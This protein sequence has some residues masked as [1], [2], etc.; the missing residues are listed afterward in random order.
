MGKCLK[1]VLFLIS[2][3]GLI[4][5]CACSHDPT[6]EES[7]ALD[8]A[9]EYLEIIPMSK[10]GII[11]QLI[12]DGCEKDDAAFAANH[13]GADWNEQA[14]RF[15]KEFYLEYG[16]NREELIDKLITNAKFTQKQAEYAADQNGW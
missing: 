8:R 2:I 7:Y 3:V 16:Y 9:I 10:D 6:P 14:D 11:D 5:T 12:Y 15:V 4:T 1:K 13:C